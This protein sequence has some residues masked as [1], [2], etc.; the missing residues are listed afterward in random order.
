MSHFIARAPDRWK[1]KPHQQWQIDRETQRALGL[2]A[3]WGVLENTPGLLRDLIGLKHMTTVAGDITY[4]RD[5]DRG[6]YLPL[7]SDKQVYLSGDQDFQISRRCH[8]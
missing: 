4:A 6:L 3:Y 1:H 7:G 5:N 2:I 8:L